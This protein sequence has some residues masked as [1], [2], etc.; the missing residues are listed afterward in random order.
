VDHVDDTCPEGFETWRS[1][2]AS[3]TGSESS[4]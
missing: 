3:D 1:T 2:V 4:G